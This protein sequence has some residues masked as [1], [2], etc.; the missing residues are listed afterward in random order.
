MVV[1]LLLVLVLVSFQADQ[2][3]CDGSGSSYQTAGA[4]EEPGAASGPGC[5]EGVCG[6]W[7]SRRSKRLTTKALAPV[8]VLVLGLGLL[9][10]SHSSSFDQDQILEALFHIWSSSAPTTRQQVQ[11]DP[12]P[13]QTPRPEAPRRRR[14]AVS[15]EPDQPRDIE[16]AQGHQSRSETSKLPCRRSPANWA[17]AGS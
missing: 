2:M 16:A 3:S 6:A 7:R 9:R 14:S 12:P 15:A 13:G 17:A 11:L 1:L 5:P 8:L 4:A 10:C